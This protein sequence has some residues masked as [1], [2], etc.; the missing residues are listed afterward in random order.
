MHL[1]YWERCGTTE[2]MELMICFKKSLVELKYESFEQ[3]IP[4]FDD[5]L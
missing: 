5:W 1:E 2:V 3:M 4:Y